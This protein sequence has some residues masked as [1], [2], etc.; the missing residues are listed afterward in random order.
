MFPIPMIQITQQYAKI[1]FDADLGSYDIKQP[2]A[3]LEIT[4]TPATVDIYS[5]RGE[6]NINQSKAW[7]ALGV[8]GNLDWTLQIYTQSK[9]IALQGIARIVEDG[10]RM[11]ASIHSKSNPIADMAR[12]HAYAE[13]VPFE[14]PSP[15]YDHVDINYMPRKPEI[16]VTVGKVNIDSHPNQPE[17]NYTRGKFDSYMQQYNSIKIIPPEIDLQL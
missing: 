13:L 6:L 11:A 8:G 17:I 9:N 3:T 2:R 10:N 12:E 14:L 5:P 4:S 1:G 15:S 7:D 16:N